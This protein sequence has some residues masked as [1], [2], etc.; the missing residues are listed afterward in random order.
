MSIT[1]QDVAM[2][3][4]FIRFRERWTGKVL[5]AGVAGAIGFTILYLRASTRYDALAAGI[6]ERTTESGIAGDDLAYVTLGL[7]EF[8]VN[9]GYH[10]ATDVLIGGISLGV[11]VAAMFPDKY[12]AI[13]TKVAE[14]DPD[15]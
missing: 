10:L 8:G 7:Y 14:M 1:S 9:A 5:V 12:R 4:D 15:A 3:Q 6:V 2:A 11:A 13:F